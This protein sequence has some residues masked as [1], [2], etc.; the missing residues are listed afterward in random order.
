MELALGD[1]G[2]AGK[3]E[4]DRGEAV[5]FMRE[6]AGRGRGGRV[7]GARGH[8]GAAAPCEEVGAEGG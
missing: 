4:A 1:G 8:G 2:T 7:E 3:G 6:V 5:R